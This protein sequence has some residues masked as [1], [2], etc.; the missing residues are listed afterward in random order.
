MS[1]DTPREGLPPSIKANEA[2]ISLGTPLPHLWR[3][4]AQ[5]RTKFRDASFLGFTASANP[6]GDLATFGEGEAEARGQ[7]PERGKEKHEYVMPHPFCSSDSN[8]LWQ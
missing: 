6:A 3:A 4:A 7:R 1:Q 8:N 2:A 5:S